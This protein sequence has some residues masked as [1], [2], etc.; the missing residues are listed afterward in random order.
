MD[1]THWAGLNLL[2]LLAAGLALVILGVRREELDVRE[3]LARLLYGD[4][5][6]QA[7]GPPQISRSR[8]LLLFLGVLGAG[9]ALTLFLWPFHRAAAGLAGAGVAVAGL[10][11][12]RRLSGSREKREAAEDI[13][14]SINGGKKPMAGSLPSRESLV[15]QDETSSSGEFG[16]VLY[17]LCQD[18][19][20]DSARR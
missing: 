6:A 10:L 20:A 2:L 12:S 13:L 15:S 17:P 3:T 9:A 19:V 7:L 1:T 18:R 8:Q 5:Q 11:W 4:E 14:A 16:M